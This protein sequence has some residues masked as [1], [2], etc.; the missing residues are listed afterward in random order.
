MTSDQDERPQIRASIRGAVATTFPLIAGI[1]PIALSCPAS[2]RAGS[3]FDCEL[4]L[5]SSNVPAA[6]HLIASS[7]GTN[8]KIPAEIATLPG[9]TRLTFRGYAD[10][11]AA[12]N[13]G[14][15]VR[16]GDTAVSA[17]LFVTAA[18]G[19][20]LEYPKTIDAAFGKP[21]SFTVSAVDPGGMPVS[22]SAFALPEGA[23]FEAATGSFTW[24]PGRLQ[25]GV[26][27]IGLLARN[28]ANGSSAGD[29]TIVMDS[30]KPAITGITNAAS[31][32]QPACSPGSIARLT[33]RWLSTNAEPLADPSG[34]I[35]LGGT[36]VRVNGEYVS[37]VYA[38]PARVDFVCPK[39]E[40]GTT[41]AVSVENA[42][43]TAGPALTVMYP[44]APGLY[45]WDGTGSGQ[46]LVAFAGSRMLAAS[47]DYLGLGFPAEPGALITI[48]CTGIGESHGAAPI[49]RI[50]GIFARVESVSAMPGS[51][52]RFRN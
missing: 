16:F 10:P 14:I 23:V 51:G 45:S 36:R 25:Q 52:G 47:R 24:T 3:W 9:Q 41:L 13:S 15:T 27:R 31:M 20:V 50:G 11:R 37:V 8:L 40:P 21:V 32:A 18:S 35:E 39:S 17:A 26:Y 33:G 42:S 43:G 34:V 19:P 12:G 49:V 4:H 38:S 2:I 22:L 7:A 46:G 28:S 48:R 1:R 5:N 44:T 30:G 29:V 6:A